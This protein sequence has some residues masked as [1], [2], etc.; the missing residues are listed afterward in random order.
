[1]DLGGELREDTT[2]N[3][4]FILKKGYQG[5]IVVEFGWPDLKE[6]VVKWR[7]NWGEFR[8]L[9]QAIIAFIKRIT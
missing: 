2:Q 4:I 8:Q 7:G 3:L 9:H 1:M 5:R 6:S